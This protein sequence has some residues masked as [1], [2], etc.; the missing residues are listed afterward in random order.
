MD[1]RVA[2]I[3]Y[4]MFWDPGRPEPYLFCKL[5]RRIASP[6]KRCWL[7]TKKVLTDI[8]LTVWSHICGLSNTRRTEE[9]AE[10]G[11]SVTRQI[12][13]ALSTES[14]AMNYFRKSLQTVFSEDECV[15]MIMESIDDKQQ[16][17]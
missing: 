10:M 3:S 16:E 4:D 1:N 17:M 14:P 12:P 7:V 15:D 13:E 2:R 11:E 6:I 5:I 8:R 9:D